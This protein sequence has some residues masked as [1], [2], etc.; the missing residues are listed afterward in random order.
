MSLKLKRFKLTQQVIVVFI[1]AVFLPLLIAGFLLVNINQHSVR[2]ELYY[3]AKVTLDNVNYRLL[4]SI[5][6]PTYNLK[7]IANLITNKSLKL[8][9]QEI[10]SLIQYIVYSVPQIRSIE[11][12]SNKNV[13][14]MSYNPDNLQS[15]DFLDFESETFIIVQKNGNQQ[16]ITLYCKVPKNIYDYKV[17]KANLN[18]NV[19]QEVIFSNISFVNRYIRVVNAE[20]YVVFAYPQKKTEIDSDHR[21]AVPPNILKE[22]KVGE[23]VRFGP[24]KNQPALF[25]KVPNSNLSIIIYTP[26]SVTFYGIMLA[27]QRI[28]I[29]LALAA[30]LS[31]ILG[32]IYVSALNRNIRQLIKAVYAIALGNYSRKI[33]LIKGYFTPYELVFLADEFNA[34]A[35]KI[36]STLKA[37]KE[38][39]DKL[40]QLDKLKSNLIDTVS[41]EF[42]TPLTSIMGYTSR[43]MRHDIEIPEELRKKSLKV[44]K[45][46]AERLNRMVDDLLVIPDL[47]SSMLR[48]YTDNIELIPILER[49][50]AYF[51]NKK[52]NTE[53]ILYI[54]ENIPTINTD[55]DR[56]EQVMVNLISNAMKYSYDD[57]NIIVNVDVLKDNNSIQID[58]INECDPI[59]EEV[60][61]TLFD[62]FKRLDDNLTRTT[63][64]SGLG[65]YISKGIVEAMGGEI[66][67]KY[68]D[69]FKATIIL[70]ITNE[71]EVE[72]NHN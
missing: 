67:L 37:L 13:P 54:P 2:K 32:F 26:Q 55:P 3:S 60:L 39:N 25:Y 72:V 8:S 31:I 50:I 33:R 46:Q 44:I 42:R 53:V 70:P 18:N 29:V 35:D 12:Y 23:V 4:S 62:K 59:S 65:L 68:D 17:I 10:L 58:F 19:M 61:S 38:A 9:K 43:L 40:A 64:G 15:F 71:K 1:I 48:F 27:R 57:T 16:I 20:G 34:M 7:F 56:L 47:E 69:K 52:P 24:F 51:K 63:R 30:V 21:F 22:S 45:E 28:L 11:I 36:N 14:V 41:H 66:L 5:D 49:S 6:I